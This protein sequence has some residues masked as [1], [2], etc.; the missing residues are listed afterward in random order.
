MIKSIIKTFFTLIICFFA[1]GKG[2]SQQRF[3]NNLRLWNDMMM[4]PA[5]I[6]ENHGTSIYLSHRQQFWRLGIQSPNVTIIGGKTNVKT[7]YSQNLL[8]SQKNRGLNYNYA[9]GGYYIHSF[10]GGVYEQN[11]ICGQFGIQWKI[12]Q[13][14]ENPS[15]YD[16]FNFGIS[17]KGINNRYRGN[18]IYLYDEFDPVYSSAIASNNYA[19]SVVPGIQYINDFIQ[20]DGF[21]TFGQKDQEFASLTV[22]GS[23][24]L[25]GFLNK[26][27]LRV[28]YFGNPNCQISINKVHDLGYGISNQV[29]SLNYGANIFIGRKFSSNSSVISNPGLFLGIIYKNSGKPTKKN[30]DY[31]TPMYQNIFSGVVN[32]VDANFNTISLGPSAEGGFMYS[33]NSSI[34]ECDRIYDRFLLP[35]AKKTENLSNLKSYESEF[36]RKCNNSDYG[37][38]YNKYIV[39]I[40]KIITELEDEFK[41]KKSLEFESCNIN[42]QEWYCQDLSFTEG[43]TFVSNQVDWDRLSPKQACYCYINFDERNKSYGLLYNSKAFKSISNNPLLKKSGF[44]V[45]EKQDWDK[46]FINAKKKGDVDRLYNCDG[47]NGNGFNLKPTGYFDQGE[48]YKPEAGQASYWVGEENVLVFLCESKGEIMEDNIEYDLD[49]LKERI[50]KSAFLI[51]IIKY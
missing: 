36:N 33:R 17:I 7:Y 5:K 13:T 49:L 31:K 27:A 29:W 37:K 25:N 35:D 39:N 23:P 38:G 19:I 44:R 28:N 3:I 40:R 18:T 41:N 42:G 1:V 10:T 11:E 46:L 8:L 24:E 47:R 12:N 16:Q 21:Y 51:R 34:C 22:M 45:A 32:V 20:L 14:R 4:N 15:D 26:T 2:F 6:M 43:I 48:W 9:I 50:E 30:A